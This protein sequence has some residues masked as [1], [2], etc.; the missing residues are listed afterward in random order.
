VIELSIYV[1][2]VDGF[3]IDVNDYRHHSTTIL[4]LGDLTIE[5]QGINTILIFHWEKENMVAYPK[6][7]MRH[8]VLVQQITMMMEGL[9]GPTTI[10]SFVRIICLD[11]IFKLWSFR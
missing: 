3:M 9:G 7:F 4:F 2:Y 6:N 5:C 1:G 11:H 8:G 10:V